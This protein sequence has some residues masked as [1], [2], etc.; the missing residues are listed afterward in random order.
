MTRKRNSLC[1]LFTIM[2]MLSTLACG[3]KNPAVLSP[4]VKPGSAESLSNEGM[5]FFNNGNL[6]QARNRFQA[7]LAKNPN[8][9]DAILGMGLIHLNQ[10]SL[11]DSLACFEQLKRLTPASYDVYNYL[12]II[13]LEME[14]FAKARENLLIAAT[15]ETYQ[16]PENA[17]ANLAHLELKM[18]NPEAA[19]RYVRKGLEKKKNFALLHSLEGQIH[20]SLKQWRLA[21][22]AYERA[23]AVLFNKDSS[24]LIRIARM[25]S[26]LGERDKALD[27]LESSLGKAKTAAEKQAIINLIAE[28]NSQR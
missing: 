3:K 7:A 20:E 21:L 12:G 9:I 5:A 1:I 25:H 15:S 16:T 22:A 26:H 13:Y 14:D 10:R 2:L 18:N 28:I 6:E 4:Q 19:M 23:S 27:I 17:Y 11:A 8:H 24:I